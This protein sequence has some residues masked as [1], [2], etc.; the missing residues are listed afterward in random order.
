[1]VIKPFLRKGSHFPALHARGHDRDP[2]HASRPVWDV[3]ADLLETLSPETLTR[4]GHVVLPL[5]AVFARIIPPVLSERGSS[6]AEL[7]IFRKLS[8]Q[9]FHIARLKRNIGIKVSHYVEL[10]RRS[11]HKCKGNRMSL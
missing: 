3:A 5:K 2:I 10:K 9:K 8:H 11:P 4:P 1:M 6:H 7:S